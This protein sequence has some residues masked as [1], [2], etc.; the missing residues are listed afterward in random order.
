LLTRF[1]EQVAE[2]VMLLSDLE[3]GNRAERKA[4]SRARLAQAPGRAP[5][6]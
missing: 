2:G 5:A 1:G 4:K 3:R 6:A